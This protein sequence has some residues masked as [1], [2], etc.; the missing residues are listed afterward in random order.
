VHV[1][2]AEAIGSPLARN[3]YGVGIAYKAA[4]SHR[5]EEAGIAGWTRT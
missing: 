5:A 4:A 1:D 2:D 3:G